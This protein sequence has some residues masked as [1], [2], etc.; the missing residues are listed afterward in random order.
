MS[1]ESRR[2]SKILDIF[3]A[4]PSNSFFDRKATTGLDDLDDCAVI[5]VSDETEIVIGSDFVRGAGFNLFKEGLLNWEDI[6]YYLIGANASDI[7]AMGARPIGSVA[8]VRYTKQMDDSEFES[9]M[10][11]III[12]CKDFNMP[13][14]GG[15]TGGYDCSV[16][17]ATAIGACPIGKS[18][19]RA[20]GKT[21]DQIYLTGD[22]GLAGAAM[23]YFLRLKKQSVFFSK[24]EESILLSAWK[25]IRPA[26]AQGMAL[27]ENDLSTCAI[28]TSDGL[29]AAC[30]QIAEPSGLDAVLMPDEVPIAPLAKKVAEKLSI[31]PLL[32]AISD[33]VDF[34]LV[35]TSPLSH[36]EKLISIFRENEWFLRKIGELSEPISENPQVLFQTK[37]GLIP[38][39]G[40][41]WD[42]NDSL[43]VDRLKK[44]K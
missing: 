5:P 9:I 11:G 44:S 38:A 34:R 30:R 14:L 36:Q 4:I 29:R 31:D 41:E 2:I 8:V 23:A 28:D 35:F 26:I 24:E 25:K 10:R 37:N 40:V 15:D 12:A 42:Q 32:F 17:S 27:I 43:S 6:G 3:K 21:G 7:A 33:S 22:V 19:L 20:N 16:L 13:L 1:T 18:L 39:G